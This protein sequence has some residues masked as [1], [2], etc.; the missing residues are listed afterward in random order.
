MAIGQA[1]NRP[2]AVLEPAHR[3]V[4]VQ[5]GRSARQAPV[6]TDRGEPA[7]LGSTTR[8][9][10]R[11]LDTPSGCPG[12]RLDDDINSSVSLGAESSNGS[13]CTENAWASGG[14]ISQINGDRTDQFHAMWQPL[15]GNGTL[16]ATLTAFDAGGTYY[17]GLRSGPMFRRGLDASSRFYGL[18]VDKRQILHTP[19]G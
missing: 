13:P 5:K 9:G 19:N 15:Q 18:F 8:G 1:G 16:S 17:P 7:A 10:F 6:R 11:P 12:G 4:W 3:V 14:G 2:A